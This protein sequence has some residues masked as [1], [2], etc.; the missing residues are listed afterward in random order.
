MSETFGAFIAL[1]LEGEDPETA[2]GIAQVTLGPVSAGRSGPGIVA[3]EVGIALVTWTPGSVVAAS[4]FSSS[5]WMVAAS[6]LC[7]S[8]S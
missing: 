4:A 1:L 5:L 2:A 3:E 8:G 7:Q 6:V